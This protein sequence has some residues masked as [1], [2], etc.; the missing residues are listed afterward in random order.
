M[1]NHLCSGGIEARGF[2]EPASI[3][4]LVSSPCVLVKSGLLPEL[5][6]AIV[7][8]KDAR[9]VSKARTVSK[10][11]GRRDDAS[12]LST[13]D[14]ATCGGRPRSKLGA[15]AA[16]EGLENPIKV[17]GN[18]CATR[19]LPLHGSLFPRELRREIT[20]GRI[21]HGGSE[22]LSLLRFSEAP[23][24]AVEATAAEIIPRV[25]EKEVSVVAAEATQVLAPPIKKAN[26]EVKEHELPI[27]A[28]AGS[29]APVVLK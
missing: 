5:S 20:L 13:C 12:G 2:L 7:A 29:T 16:A 26:P 8:G 19:C 17:L 18:F 1:Q 15:A 21:W 25:E 4:A 22:L 28:D 11:R 24:T 23:Q 3:E 14:T 6:K 9:L 27:D 10:R